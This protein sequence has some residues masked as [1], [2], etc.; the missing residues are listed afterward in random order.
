MADYSSAA[1]FERVFERVFPDLN[2]DS[3]L[4]SAMIN[5]AW[6]A[7]DGDPEAAHRAMHTLADDCLKFAAAIVCMMPDSEEGFEG[8]E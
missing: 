1:D 7:S 2:T 5:E 8:D 4:H 3:P 6:E